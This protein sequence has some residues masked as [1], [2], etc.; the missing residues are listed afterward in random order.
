MIVPLPVSGRGIV[1]SR[2][3]AVLLLLTALLFVPTT[4]HLGA[5]PETPVQIRLVNTTAQAL[6]YQIDDQQE[7]SIAME[8]LGE[9]TDLTEGRH[10]LRVSSDAD[11]ESMTTGVLDLLA[12]AAT[13]VITTDE[14]APLRI[15]VVYDAAPSSYTAS[16]I[17]LLAMLPIAAQ[18]DVVTEP[19]SDLSGPLADGQRRTA[20]LEAGAYALTAGVAAARQSWPLE[21][22]PRTL[23]HLVLVDRRPAHEG[24]VLFVSVFTVS[25]SP[26]PPETATVS[27][28]ASPTV[29]PPAVTLA[30]SITTPIPDATPAVVATPTP[31]PPVTP[32]PPV[33]VA[34]P[35]P[36]ILVGALPGTVL[37]SDAFDDPANGILPLTAPFTTREQGYVNSEYFIRGRAG[38]SGQ[39]QLVSLPGSYGDVSLMIDAAFAGEYTSR[40]LYLGCR[41]ASS[42]DTGAGA[43]GYRMVADTRTG[44]VEMRRYDNGRSTTVRST[45]VRAMNRGTSKNRFG[46]SCKG[47]TI[48]A[49]VNGVTVLAVTDS[50]YREGRLYIGVSS[51]ANLVAEG[52]FDNLLVIQE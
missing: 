14:G 7:Q 41:Y 51:G 8:A 16:R 10:L 37:L 27:S 30:A 46:I 49:L 32:T 19:D 35:E 29:A 2:L 38:G 50:R 20:V 6:R 22:G 17:Q 43:Q 31:P 12:G 13:V 47:T 25:I 44:E 24:V 21:V 1:R 26:T 5:Q 9:R 40:S 18:L 39:S 11:A 45:V 34:R 28:T 42:N 3:Y 52:R 4:P 15:S 48:S 36:V 23:M 33:V